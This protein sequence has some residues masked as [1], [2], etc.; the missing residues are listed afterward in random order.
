LIRDPTFRRE[1][2]SSDSA[3]IMHVNRSGTPVLMKRPTRVDRDR[4]AGGRIG[5]AESDD[6]LG[7]IVLIGGALEQRAGCGTLDLRVREIGCGTRPRYRSPDERS[8]I[9]LSV[10]VPK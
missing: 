4:H 1:R 5:A 7:A 2:S 8:D 10:R 6:L 3:T 9:R